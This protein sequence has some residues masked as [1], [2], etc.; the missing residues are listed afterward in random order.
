M[1]GTLEPASFKP[2][3]LTQREHVLGR[4]EL[5]AGDTPGVRPHVGWVPLHVP[6]PPPAAPRRR[7]EAST[8]A[9]VAHKDDVEDT[10]ASPDGDSDADAGADAE[11]EA[12]ADADADADDDGDIARIKSASLAGA[13]AVATDAKTEGTPR[14]QQPRRAAHPKRER[15]VTTFA[16]RTDVQYAGIL[17]KM[18]DEVLVNVYDAAVKAL[19]SG[20]TPVTRVDVRV[21]AA[22]G[23]ITARN[24][25][26]GVPVVKMDV[27]GTETWAPSAL[28]GRM[29]ASTNFGDIKELGGSGAPRESGGVNGIGIKLVNVLSREFTVAATDAKNMRAFKQTWRNN[30]ADAGAASVREIKPRK[31]APAGYT[32]ISFVPDLL[33]LGY[34]TAAPVL[35]AAPVRRPAPRAKAAAPKPPPSLTRTM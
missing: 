17:L 20:G 14:T 30:M 2:Q 4:P 19:M 26:G 25:G 27:E 13:A 9:A 11:A 15:L 33:R 8:T 29:L 18:V 21:D 10:V 3:A 32:E 23:R 16:W 28:F 1:S 31:K 22:T 5:Y 12:D 7:K 34:D 6:A 24:N 35:A